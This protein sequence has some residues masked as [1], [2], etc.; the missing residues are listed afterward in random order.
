[1][2]VYLRLAHDL[3]IGK[4]RKKIHTKQTTKHL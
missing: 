1:M 3:Q 2:I 4:K